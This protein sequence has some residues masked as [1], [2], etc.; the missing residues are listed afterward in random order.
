MKERE[1]ESGT[2]RRSR[3]ICVFRPG[4]A[5]RNEQKIPFARE[6]I[7]RVRPILT[8]RWEELSWR[9]SIKRNRFSDEGD[10]RTA[11]TAV[12]LMVINCQNVN[13]VG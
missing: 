9:T 5:V 4:I 6:F 12:A 13:S 11:G 2:A 10:N 1:R 3:K 7:A 8:E